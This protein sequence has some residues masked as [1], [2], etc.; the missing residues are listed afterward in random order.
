MIFIQVDKPETKP[1]ENP[2]KD[3]AVKND[4]ANLEEEKVVQPQPAP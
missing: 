4:Q 3:T 2:A 1:A